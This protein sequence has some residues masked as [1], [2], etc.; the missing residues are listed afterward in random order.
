MNVDQFAHNIE[1][2]EDFFYLEFGV[3]EFLNFGDLGLI[4]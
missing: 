2:G 4:E 1:T 3:N